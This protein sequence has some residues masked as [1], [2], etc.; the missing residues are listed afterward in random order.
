MKTIIRLFLIAAVSLL[1]QV[2]WADAAPQVYV[3]VNMPTLT[4]N[5]GLLEQN[6]C[7][8]SGIIRVNGPADLDGPLKY[9]CD[10][11]YSYVAAGSSNQSIRFNGRAIHHSEIV[12]ENGKARLELAEKVAL[13]LS[14]NPRQVDVVEIGCEAV[15]Q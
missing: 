11:R 4:C 6:E 14:E 15:H 8:L 9:F 12:V 1:Q 2:T 13:K 5:K 7:I 3:Q 10:I